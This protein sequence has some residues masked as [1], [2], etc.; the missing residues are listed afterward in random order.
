MNASHAP[1]TLFATITIFLA[2]AVSLVAQ[3][4]EKSAGD[5]VDLFDGTTLDGWRG[6][7]QK[8]VPAS[9]EVRDGCIYCKGKGDSLMTSK[10]YGDYELT[11]DWKI[12]KGGNSGIILRSV[13]R[14][15]GPDSS[16]ME[17]QVIDHPEGWKEVNGYA[18]GPG[19]SAGALYAIY[20]AKMASVKKAGEWNTTRVL[21][22][23]T[24]IKLWHNG[25]VVTDDDMTSEEWQK[26]LAASKFGKSELFNKALSGHIAFQNYQGGGV[27]YRKVR[28]REIGSDKKSP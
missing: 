5:W 13:E 18:I 21:L 6:F 23:G 15:G 19:Q 27:W 3:E 24:K 4:S 17:V 11:V 10:T 1:R 2:T 20:P 16:G 22:H 9:W 8:E 28:I 7:K 26:R 12:I 14:G 25:V